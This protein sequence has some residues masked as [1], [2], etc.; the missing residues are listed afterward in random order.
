MSNYGH[1]TSPEEA[2]FNINSPGFYLDVRLNAI[3]NG[4][5]YDFTGKKIFNVEFFRQGVG[6]GITNIDIEVNTSLQPVIT[7][8]MKDLYGNAVF[9][10]NINTGLSAQI[11]DANAGGRDDGTIDFSVL[12]NWPPPKFLFTFKGYLG[13]QVSWL[14]NLKKTSTTYQSD[15]SYDIKCEFVPNQWGFMAD[16]PFLYLLA[17]KGLKKNEQSPEKFKEVSTIFDLIK[18]GK[19][20]EIKTKETT[21]EFDGLLKQMTLLKANRI[22]EAVVVSKVIKFDETIDGSV[23]SLKVKDFAPVTIKQPTDPILANTESIKSYTDGGSEQLRLA[24]AFLLLTSTIGAFPPLLGLVSVRQLSV[25]SVGTNAPAALTFNGNSVE[26]EVSQ[27]LKTITDNIT[28]IEKSIKQKT[29]QSSKTQLEQITIGEVFK[30]LASDAGYVMGKILQ[31]GYKAYIDNKEIRDAQ[32]KLLI[33]RQFPLMIDSDGKEVPAIGLP[34][35]TDVGVE[36]GEMVFVDQFITAITEGIANDLLKEGQDAATANQENAL[37]KRINNLEAIK[38]NPYAPAYR[39]ITENMFVRSGIISF[40]TRSNDP[41]VPGDYGTTTGLF[42]RDSV[43]EVIQ[44]AGADMENI[45]TGMLSSMPGDE[46]L[47]LKNFCL[48]WKNFISTDGK[49]FLKEDGN[50]NEQDPVPTFNLGSPLSSSLKNKKIAIAKDANGKPTIEKTLENII[51]EVFSSKSGTN[52]DSSNANFINPETLQS[53]RVFNNGI[54]YSVPLNSSDKYIFTLFEA[55]DAS[56]VKEV[57][58]SPS[59]AES[60]NDNADNPETNDEPLGFIAIDTFK[61]TDGKTLG[62]IDIINE[63][64]NVGG[65]STVL[66]YTQMSNPSQNLFRFQTQ[67]TFQ[68][69]CVYPTNTK[70]VDPAGTIN[71]N[72]IP[73]RNL[74]Y[75]VSM[76]PQGS[77]LSLVFAPFFNS[78]SATNQRACMVKMC[79]DLLQKMTTLEE[80]KN[81]IISEVLGKATEQRAGL[82]KQMHVLY[83]QWESLMFEDPKDDNSP[84]SLI[85]KDGSGIADEMSGRYNQKDSHLSADSTGPISD[86]GTNAFIYD[87]P[88]N[89]TTNPKIKVENSIINIES[90]YKPNGNTTVLNIIQNICTKNN[91]VFI[92]IPGNGDFKD[93]G[94]IFTPHVATST[95]LK[96]FFYVMFAATPESR[97]KIS[98]DNNSP[99]SYSDTAISKI[100]QNAYEVR[101]GSVD[102]KVFK[103]VTIDTNENKTTAESIVN[104]Q[105]LVDKENQNK[106]VTTDCSMLPVMEGRSY[107]ASFDMLGN[108]QVFPMQYFYLNS[109]PLFNGLYQVL[110]VKHNIKPNDMTTTA[111]GVRMRFNFGNGDFGGVP[112]VTL[113][114]LGSIDAIE[115][116]KPDYL[117]MEDLNKNNDDVDN[118]TV[119]EN[120]SIL[121][122]TKSSEGTPI[123]A[124]ERQRTGGIFY[125]PVHGYVSSDWLDRINKNATKEDRKKELLKIAPP[126]FNIPLAH[127][128]FTSPFGPRSVVAGHSMHPGIDVSD[129]LGT[130]VYAVAA[131]VVVRVTANGNGGGYGNSII[132]KHNDRFYSLYGHLNKTLVKEGDTV[133]A[134][135]QIAEE[136][137]T[138][139]GKIAPKLKSGKM[140]AHLHFEIRDFAV[141]DT[142]FGKFG[143]VNPQFYIYKATPN[144]TRF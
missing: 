23:N 80:E 126:V 123:Y 27:R 65:D 6:F 66:N 105:R 118:T 138:E 101:V 90:L 63:R 55:Q 74:A 119:A 127:G 7:I 18:I 72:D 33:G 76:H 116:V 83:N 75:T 35:T 134:A 50:P 86:L 29:Y 99:I 129:G 9:G 143:S 84:P 47:Q 112:P 77:D 49:Y 62:R 19:Q 61:D 16:L 98:N 4:S 34:L 30:H 25:T 128:S 1:I 70:I 67:A 36:N 14:L 2:P 12:F 22:V 53:Q 114:G 115:G 43:E 73:A 31:T 82:Y 109:I 125:E 59:D 100:P 52:L 60:K 124:T 20:V 102:N 37:T 139:D 40:L 24:N 38:G 71:A 44:L 41:N 106:T 26:A 51:K 81:Q 140:G 103:G 92:P 121:S 39:T 87:Y 3:V 142:Q 88:L 130:K 57:N 21:K 46:F 32:E 96:N 79:S 64:F 108:A 107:K 11:S 137:N 122:N 131:G 104:L 136:G 144:G 85:A 117:A 42:D 56:K 110:K 94:D 45:S 8:T 17:V 15:G 93:Y 132:I 5:S 91:F 28:Q 69:L 89:P 141:S 133:Q 48:F 111:E 120:L 135:Q 78:K 95:S 97:S 113:E 54:I 10:K 13:K 68:Q 58:N